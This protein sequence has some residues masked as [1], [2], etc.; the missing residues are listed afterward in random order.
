VTTV[1]GDMFTQMRFLWASDRLLAH[2][3]AFAAGSVEEPAL[4]TSRDVLEFAT[5]EG[6]RVCGLDDRTGS[7]TPG[8]QADLVVVRCD[9]S[10]TYPV[11]DPVATVVHQADTRNVDAVLVAGTFLKRDGKLVAGDLRGARERAA[12]SLDHLL[13]HTTVQPHWV[14]SARGGAAAQAH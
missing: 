12:G 8:K 9:Q 11:I 3:A 4:L 2:E 6:A 13:Q 5:I 14:Q 1:P 7:L 10:N